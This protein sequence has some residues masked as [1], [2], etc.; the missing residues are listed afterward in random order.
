MFASVAAALAA[1]PELGPRSRAAIEVLL[2]GP[3]TLLLP[4]P[5]RRYSAACGNDH[6]TLGLRVPVLP[7]AVGDFG[8]AILQSSANIAGGPDP[9]KVTDIPL[10]IR[11]HVQLV[12][13]AGELPGTP[14]TVIDLTAYEE[15]KSWK[16]IRHGATTEEEITHSLLLVCS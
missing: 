11:E 1:L 13:D 9:L 15:D 6:E 3:I 10:S 5:A 8:G 14:S 2:P 7:E 16:T 12:I 4:N